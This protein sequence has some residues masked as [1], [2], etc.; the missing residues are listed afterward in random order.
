MNTFK[1]PGNTHSKT[2]FSVQDNLFLLFLIQI[3]VEACPKFWF[4]WLMNFWCIPSKTTQIMIMESTIKSPNSNNQ[5]FLFCVWKY[6]LN[7]L[8]HRKSYLITAALV[9]LFLDCVLLTRTRVKMNPTT[10]PSNMTNTGRWKKINCLSPVAAIKQLSV[11]M[12]GL[13]SESSSTYAWRTMINLQ[14]FKINMF[15]QFQKIQ[16]YGDIY[17]TLYACQFYLA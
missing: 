4:L 9:F 16:H 5:N 7:W 14:V 12:L 17:G 3:K 1:Y 8:K 13:K 11:P 6:E 15:Y 10:F 2:H